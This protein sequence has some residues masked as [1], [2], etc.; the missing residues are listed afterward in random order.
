MKQFRVDTSDSVV[1]VNRD[2]SED[3]RDGLTECG[4]EEVRLDLR[5]K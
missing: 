4:K 2:S 5:V 1:G 3:S